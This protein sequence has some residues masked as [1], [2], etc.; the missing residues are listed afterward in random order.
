MTYENFTTGQLKNL[1]H[2]LLDEYISLDRDR[3]L[4]VARKHAYEKLA[5]KSSDILNY[6]RVHFGNMQQRKEMI[7]AISTIRDMIKSR[8]RKYIYRGTPEYADPIMV[9]K[10]FEELKNKRKVIHS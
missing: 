8:K 4:K 9:R 6:G 5:Q 7:H 1:G 10:A 2:K 3:C